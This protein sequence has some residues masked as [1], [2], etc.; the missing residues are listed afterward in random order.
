MNP[1]YGYA[2]LP[3]A[4]H[5]AAVASGQP[6]PTSVTLINPNI[7]N[8]PSTRQNRDFAAA[9]PRDVTLKNYFGD[10]IT[11]NYHFPT[12]DVKYIGGYQ[13]YDYDLNYSTPDSDVSSY[14][15]PGQLQVFRPGRRYCAWVACAKCAGD[16]PLGGPQLPRKRPLDEPRDQLP[17]V[18]GRAV[19]M[20]GRRLLLLPTLQQPDP[21]HRPGSTATNAS[22]H[23]PARHPRLSRRDYGRGQTRR[24][25][26]SSTATNCR[27]RAKA[28]MGKRPTRSTT[29]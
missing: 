21:G 22:L 8:N 26:S 25:S 7:L 5:N 27:W 9:L 29:T 3:G 19:P 16:Q 1:N 15:L 11:F 6:V 14:T 23:R 20:A 17:I 28:A 10:Q 4:A 2:A 13:Q 24:T 18:D 12:F